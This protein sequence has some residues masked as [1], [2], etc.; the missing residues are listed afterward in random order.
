MPFVYAPDR[1]ELIRSH[2]WIGGGEARIYTM[3][4]GE[5]YKLARTKLIVPLRE[6]ESAPPVST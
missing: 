5:A 3:R 6:I 1:L 4:E 2:A